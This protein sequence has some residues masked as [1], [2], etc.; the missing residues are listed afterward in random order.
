MGGLNQTIKNREMS[1][2]ERQTTI[3]EQK[4]LLVQAAE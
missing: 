2:L 1:L 3:E 4:V